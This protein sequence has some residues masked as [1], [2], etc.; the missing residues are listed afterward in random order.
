MDGLLVLPVAGAQRPGVEEG[1][2][3]GHEHDE[4]E[5]AQDAVVLD[6]EQGA[7][8]VVALVDA[9]HT[10]LVVVVAGPPADEVVCKLQGRGFRAS[11]KGGTSPVVPG[12]ASKRCC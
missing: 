9:Q 2:A 8:R 11:G 6:V 1:A 4:A 5:E 10:I 3:E 7:A 12:L